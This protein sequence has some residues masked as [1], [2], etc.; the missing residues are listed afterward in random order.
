MIVLMFD[1]DGT[2]FNTMHLHADL[3]SDTMNKYFGMPIEEARRCYLETAGISYRN[4]MYQ[5]FSGQPKE[6]IDAS[7]QEYNERRIKEVFEKSKPFPDVPKMLSELSG[8]NLFV[9]SGNEEVFIKPILEREHM[10]SFFKDVY[11]A[12]SGLKEKHIQ[13]VLNTLNPDLIVFFGDS[14]YDVKLSR[15]N[16]ITIGRAGTP[17]TG[18]HSKEKLLAEGADLVA[19]D[20]S[21]IPKILSGF[22][23]SKQELVQAIKEEIK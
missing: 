17:S 13:I 14:T 2:L 10:T 7:I 18:M 21:C 8:S 3:A 20:F 16:V 12:E 11:G 4:Q 6:K 9:S 22:K 1:F 19:E 23:G 15:K 5:I